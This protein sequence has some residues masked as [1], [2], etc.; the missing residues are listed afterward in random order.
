M[1]TWKGQRVMK[2]SA[3][4]LLLQHLMQMQQEKLKQYK[5]SMSLENE[6]PHIFAVADRMYRLLVS[7]GESQ[8]IIV[9]GPSGSGKTE[10]GT[11]CL[12]KCVAHQPA[13]GLHVVSNQHADP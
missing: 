9:S 3:Y 7:T 8:A 5:S 13:I 2:L 11:T 12:T 6:P 10:T 4:R 1:K